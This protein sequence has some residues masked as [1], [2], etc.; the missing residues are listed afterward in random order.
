[1]PIGD[2]D[3]P[4]IG[5]NVVIAIL[6]QSHVLIATFILGASL[7]APTTEYLGMVTKQPNYERF[8]RNLTKLI[9]LLFTSGSALA[10]AFVLALVTLFPIFFSTVDL[11]EYTGK[12]L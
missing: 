8:A 6:V 3:V 7:I 1:M 12:R 11:V 2:L 9:V 4:V 5:K 10:I